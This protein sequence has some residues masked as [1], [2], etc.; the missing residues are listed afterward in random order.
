MTIFTKPFPFT[1]HLCASA[2]DLAS[3]SRTFHHTVFAY[4]VSP[5][6]QQHRYRYLEE[7]KQESQSQD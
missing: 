7:K 3:P 5:N 1:Q 6:T 2:T 4:L